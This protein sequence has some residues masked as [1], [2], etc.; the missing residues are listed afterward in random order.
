MKKV[1]ICGLRRKEDILMVNRLK[2]DYDGF[3]FEDSSRNCECRNH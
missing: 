3:V 1:K 2:P